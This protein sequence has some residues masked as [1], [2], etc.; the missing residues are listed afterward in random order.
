MTTLEQII[1]DYKEGKVSTQALKKQLKEIQEQEEAKTYPLSVG[2]RGLWLLHREGDATVSAYNVPLVLRFDTKISETRI[3]K[4]CKELVNIHRLLGASFSLETPTYKLPR[5]PYIDFQILDQTGKSASEIVTFMQQL[6]DDPLAIDKAPVRFRWIPQQG[7]GGYLQLV[8]HHLVCD[9]TSLVTIF[10]TLMKLLLSENIEPVMPYED[11]VNWEQSFLK[12]PKHKSLQSYWKQILQQLPDPVSLHKDYYLDKPAN[13]IGAIHQEDFP[14]TVSKKIQSYCRQHRISVASVLLGAYQ[15]VLRKYTGQDDLI[16]GIPTLGRSQE[17][18][19]QTVGYCVNMIPIRKPVKATDSISTYLKSLQ[20]KVMEGVD[21]SNYPFP[22]MVKDHNDETL[23]QQSLP[24]FQF[25]FAYQNFIRAGAASNLTKPFENELGVH[26]LRSVHQYSNYE[27]AIEVGEIEEGFDITVKYNRALLSGERIQRFT[28]HYFTVLKAILEGTITQIQEL[29]LF[30]DDER[31]LLDEVQNTAVTYPQKS[32]IAAYL[33][34]TEL[35][36]D[37]EAIRFDQGSLTHG[38]VSEKVD[39]IATYLLDQGVRSEGRIG[40]CMQR[41]PDLVLAIM[42]ILRAGATF[43]P[44]SPDFPK[45][46]I[47]YILEDANIQCVIGDVQTTSVLQQIVSDTISVISAIEMQKHTNKQQ[48]PAISDQQQA[49]II[50]TSGSTG[51]PKGVPVTHANI[52]NT[53]HYLEA[54]YPLNAKD[55]YVFKTNYV[56]DVS[57]SEIFGWLIGKGVLYIPDLGVEKSPAKLVKMIEE[58][59]ITHIN[60]V[61]SLLRVF[62]NYVKEKNRVKECGTLKYILVAGEAFPVDLVREAVSLFSQSQVV[63]IYGPTEASIY[64][65]AFDCSKESFHA[66]NTPIGRPIANT[67]LHIRDID[68]QETGM[69]VPG[70]LCLSGNGVVSG[71]LNREELSAEKFIVNT[72]SSDPILYRTGDWV[73][74]LPDGKIEY[75]GRIDAQVKIRGYRI[76]LGE[77]EYAIRKIPTIDDVVCLVKAVHGV[78]QIWSFVQAKNSQLISGLQQQL[79]NSLPDYMVPSQIIWVPNIPVTLNGKIDRQKLLEIRPSKQQRTNAAQQSPKQPEKLLETLQVI[80]KETLE[81]AEVEVD[82]RFMEIGGD[83]ILAAVLIDRVNLTF[84]TSFDSADIF[85][86]PTIQLLAA[87]IKASNLKDENTEVERTEELLQEDISSEKRKKDPYEDAIAIVGMSCSFPG[88]QNIQDFWNLLIAEKESFRFL[89]ADE[90]MKM[91][92]PDTIIQNPQFVPVQAALDT[93]EFFDAPFF[94]V[95]KRDAG[96]MDPQLRMLLQHAWHAV[97]DAGY[98]VEKIKDTAVYI[99]SGNNFY[100][101]SLPEFADQGSG[102]L[103]HSDQYVSWIYGQGGTIPTMISYKLGLEGPSLYVH[104]NCSSSLSGLY[105]AYQSIMNGE[106]RHA[107]VGAANVGAFNSAGYIH[108]QGLNFSGD[109][110]LKAFDKDAD[111]MIGGEGVTMILVKKASEAIRDKDPIYCILKGIALNNDGSDKAGFYAPSFEGQKKVIKKVLDQT[112]IHPDSISYVEAHGTGTKLGDPIEFNALADT[113]KQY[114]DKKEYCAI[115]SVKT[116][117]GHVDTAAGLAGVIKIALSMQHQQLPA[118]LNYSS[119]NPQLKLEGSPFFISDKTRSWKRNGTPLRAAISSFGIGGTNGHAVFEQVEVAQSKES[120]S[121]P[122]PNQMVLPI[123]ARTLKRLKQYVQNI[124]DFV[125]KPNDSI[126]ISDQINTTQK[127]ESNLQ[128]FL[129]ALLN[130]AADQIDPDQVFDD[131]IS[132]TFHIKKISQW[133][134]EFYSVSLESKE[135]FQLNTLAKLS[136][137]LE[138]QL[139]PASK[140]LQFSWKQ[141]ADLCYTFQNGRKEMKHR[142]VFVFDS[143]EMLEKQWKAFLQDKNY[144]G[145]LSTDKMLGRDHEKALSG[146]LSLEEIA[147]AW[148]AGNKVD[149]EDCWTTCYIPMRISAPGYPFEE[150]R[151]PLPNTKKDTISNGIKPQGWHPLLHQNQSGFA[152]VVFQ[153]NFSGLEFFLNDHVIDGNKILP[154]VAYL[155]MALQAYYRAQG[156]APKPC[157]L[158]DIYWMQPWIQETSEQEIQCKLKL[159]A[160]A[161]LYEYSV[162]TEKGTILHSKGSIRTLNSSEKEHNHIAIE[163]FQSTASTVLTKTQIYEVFEKHKVS[164]G[165]RHRVIE[166]LWIEGNHTLVRLMMPQITEETCYWLHPAMMDGAL[167]AVIGFKIA[168]EDKSVA[169]PFGIQ[170]VVVYQPCVTQ[171]WA[172]VEKHAAQKGTTYDIYMLNDEKEVCVVIKGYQTRRIQGLDDMSA[173]ELAQEKKEDTVQV[174]SPEWVSRDAVVTD[175]WKPNVC[176]VWGIDTSV[177]EQLKKSGTTVIS[178]ATCVNR[179]D[180]KEIIRFH[181]PTEIACLIGNE[182]EEQPEDSVTFLIDAVFE[183][184]KAL[185]EEGYAAKALRW[186]V[187]TEATFQVQPEETIHHPI[188]VS[189][190]GMLGS[191]QKEYANWDIRLIDL[192]VWEQPWVQLSLPKTPHGVSWARRN[193]QW[194]QQQLLPTTIQKPFVKDKKKTKAVHPVIVIVGGAGTVGRA[195]TNHLYENTMATVVW[196]GR[197]SVDQIDWKGWESR[198]RYVQADITSAIEFENALQN[199]QNQVGPIDTLVHTTMVLADGS[200]EKLTPEQFH[201]TFDNKALGLVVIAN[202]LR[203]IRVRQLVCFSSVAS[204]VRV[205]GQTNYSAGCVFTDQYAQWIQQQ[206]SI[207]VKIINW[208]YWGLTESTEEQGTHK[209]IIDRG[210]EVLQVAPALSFLDHFLQTGKQQLVYMKLSESL[211]NTPLG[212]ELMQGASRKPSV[213]E[214]ITTPAKVRIKN[215]AMNNSTTT[216]LEQE[217]TTYLQG[218]IADVLRMEAAEIDTEEALE[219][220]GLDSILV[221]QITNELSSVFEGLQTTV[222]FEYQTI[223]EIATYLCETYPEIAQD[224]FGKQDVLDE[225]EEVVSVESTEDNEALDVIS[226]L[227][228]NPLAIPSKLST[229][230][231]SWLKQ[232]VSETTELQLSEIDERDSLD[233]YSLDSVQIIGLTEHLNSVVDEIPTTVFFESEN[234]QELANYLIS[235]RKDQLDA[236]FGSSIAPSSPVMTATKPIEPQ[237]HKP[238]TQKTEQSK[239]LSETDVAII[240]VTGSYPMAKDLEEFWKNLKEGKDCIS[241]VPSDR[242]D[243]AA[244]YD[245]DK[246]NFEKSYGKWGGFLSDV[247][248]FDPLFFNISPTEAEIMDPKERIFLETVWKLFEKTGLTRQKIKEEYD[249]MVGVYVGAMY[250]HYHCYSADILKES[251]VSMSCHSSIA[252]RVSYYFNLQGPSVAVN[253]MC[254]SSLIA[255]DMAY[256]ALLTGD[257]E[258]A[259]AGG[260]NLSLHPK[261]YIGLSATRTM[262]SHIDSRSFSDGDGYLPAEGVGAVLLKPLSRAIED[263]DQIL[264]VIKASSSNHGGR[265][266]GFTVPNLKAQTRLIEQNFKRSGI[267]PRTISYVE[268]AVNGSNLG[269]PIEIAALSKAFRKFTGEKEFCSIGTVKSNIGHAE[270]ASGIS[271]LTKV[272]LQMEHKTLVPTIKTEPM[273]QQIQ[274]GETPFVLQRT[275]TPWERPVISKVDETGIEKLTEYPRRATVSSFGAGGSNAHIIIEEYVGNVGEKAQEEVKITEKL[276]NIFVLSARK[277]EELQL[278]VQQ[279]YNYIEKNPEISITDIA[280]TLQTG[281][282]LMEHRLAIPYQS[283]E[284]LLGVLRAITQ[285]TSWKEAIKNPNVFT[286]DKKSA[287]PQITQLFKDTIGTEIL[288]LVLNRGDLNK[289]AI[290]WMSGSLIPWESIYQNIRKPSIVSLPGYPFQKKR[291]W[292]AEKNVV[293]KAPQQNVTSSK[294]QSENTISEVEVLS[295]TKSGSIK[296]L[297]KDVWQEVLGIDSIEWEDNF[298][299]LGGDSIMLTHIISRIKKEM[300]FDVSVK[301]LYQSTTLNEMAEQLLEIAEQHQLDTKDMNFSVSE[302]TGQRIPRLPQVTEPTLSFAQQRLWFLDQMVKN[303]PAYNVVMALHMKGTLKKNYLEK[304]FHQILNRHESLRTTFKTKQGEPFQQ[305]TEQLHPKILWKDLTVITESDQNKVFEE[306]AKEEARHIFNLEDGTLVRLTVFQLNQQKQILVLNAHHIVIDGWSVNV[307]FK[308]L[309]E[310]YSQ[311]LLGKEL[312]L[313]ALPIQYTD[314]ALWQRKWLQGEELE[315]QMAYWR[316]KLGSVN[317]MIEL[318]LDH[319]RPPVQTFQGGSIRLELPSGLLEN[320]RATARTYQVTLF[321]LLMGS[322]NVLLHRYSGQQEIIVGTPVNNRNRLEIE[323]LIGFFVN[324]LVIKTSMQGNPSFPQ[325]LQRLREEVNGAKMHQDLPFEQLVQELQPDRNMSQNPLFQVCFNMLITPEIDSSDLEVL[326]I[327]GVRND[328]AKFDLWV[329]VID[330]KDKMVLEVE[331]NSV[332]FLE[333][334]IV[335]LMNSYET[336]LK[337]IIEDGDRTIGEIPILTKKQQQELVIKSQGDTPDFETAICLHQIIDRQCAQTPHAIAATFENKKITYQELHEM[338]NQLANYLIKEGVQAESFVGLCM[339]RSLD[340]IIC[341]LGILKAGAAYVPIDPSYPQDRLHYILED[342]NPPVVLSHGKHK[343]LFG[344]SLQKVCYLDEI[345]EVVQRCERFSVTGT[346]STEDQLAYMIYTSGSTGKPK[347]AMITHKSIVN[348]LLWMQNEYQIGNGDKILQKTPYSFDVSV[349][350]FFWPLMQGARLVFAK[351]EGH[352]DPGYLIELIEKK[353]ITVLHFV[354]SMLQVFLEIKKTAQCMSIQKV[355]CSGEALP[356]SL[357]Q[358]FFAG[359]E[360]AA[361]HNLYGPTEAAVDVTYWSCNREDTSGFIPIGYPVAHT[362]IY[363]LDSYGNQVPQGVTGEIH[364]GGV[365]VARGYHNKEDLTKDKFIT[366]PFSLSGEGT[367]YKTGDLGRMLSDGSIEYKGRI[368]FQVKIR[369]VRIELGEIEAA[370][371]RN[372][373][374][375]ETVV[376]AKSTSQDPQDKELVAYAV[377]DLELLEDWLPKTSD[378]QTIQQ[379]D[380]WEQVFD[381]TYE[382][383]SPEKDQKDFNIIGWNSSYTGEEI[384]ANEMKVWVE[385]TVTRILD[386]K[387]QKVLEIGCGT[388]LLVSR[389]APHV[390]HYTGTDISQTGLDYIQEE[391][392]PNLPRPEQLTL[393][394]QEANDFNRIDQ[395]RYDL[396]IINSVAQY[397]G[398]YNYFMEVLKGALLVLEDDGALFLGDIRNKGLL[399]SFVMDIERYKAAEETT[400]EVLQKQV[401]NKVFQEPELL[402]DPDFFRAIAVT[403][404]AISHV[405]LDLKR[406]AFQNE[407]TRYRYDVILHVLKEKKVPQQNTVLDFDKESQAWDQVQQFMKQG[408]WD[409]IVLRNIP[410]E[411]L[412][413]IRVWETMS[414][415]SP[416][417]IQIGQLKTQCNQIKSENEIDPETIYTVGQDMKYHV[418]V[419]PGSGKRPFV[420]DAIFVKKELID[421]GYLADE[422]Y[423][424]HEYRALDKYMNAPSLQ[425]LQ[426][427]VSD[428]IKKELQEKLPEYMIPGHIV[429]LDEM[430]VNFNGKLDRKALPDIQEMKLGQEVYIAPQSP[431]QETLIDLWQ[432]ILKIETIGVADNFFKLG[433]HSLNV[434]SML[435]KAQDA[436]GGQKVSLVD[437][438]KTPTIQGLEALLAVSEEAVSPKGI[439]QELVGAETT[440]LTVLFVPYAGGAATAFHPIA[441]AI[442]QKDATISSWAVALPGNEYGEEKEEVSIQE[443][444]SRCITEINEKVKGPIAIY[445]HCVGSYLALEIAQRLENRPRNLEFVMLG[446]LL[447]IPKWYRMLPAKDPWIHKSDDELIRMLRKWGMREEAVEQDILQFMVKNFRIDAKQSYL[448]SKTRKDWKLT[449]PIINVVGTKD[450][451]TKNYQKKYKKWKEYG[452]RVHLA[453]VDTTNH[454]FVSE[455]AEEVAEIMQLVRSNPEVIQEQDLKIL[456]TL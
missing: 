297:L 414:A 198:R 194:Y 449:A 205:P 153:S 265:S 356:Y 127:I 218:V 438:Y 370:L 264:G 425:A 1:L 455:L 9:G 100:R 180:F 319:P 56:F 162:I 290:F 426:K 288:N 225:Q 441:Q 52:L 2:Q 400:L 390:Q 95:S 60:F 62:I 401:K 391:L 197:R 67:Q 266:N 121:Q 58:Q 253:T 23:L 82:D 373:I 55:V 363:I 228:E 159:A 383:G 54:T 275:T 376:L 213:V 47:Q 154:G 68:G 450:P 384:P 263:K 454:Y 341:L 372:P 98:P 274:L 348:R 78:K 433:G 19:E 175:L 35:N 179:S 260:V 237:Q 124:Y 256:K 31:Q 224:H 66:V 148:V 255:I 65:A 406:G 219:S 74:R 245:P 303:S 448:Y 445:G 411:R 335:R 379:T 336:L 296:E 340:M 287:N 229:Q 243:V 89:Q 176:W 120:T 381:N 160:T 233:T 321:E 360:K 221:V 51:K 106:C 431:T 332:I 446:G 143:P 15:L 130:V 72:Y 305:V 280:Y 145:I 164:Y 70:E 306:Q 419:V 330:Q 359:F 257:C 34:N 357:V 323:G 75:I 378:S 393:Y 388:G 144:Q 351:P 215:T 314:Y 302:Q 453:T 71:Y 77:I 420:V 138:T 94:K 276:P 16:I 308:E 172:Y 169:L 444:A 365:Q 131:Y 385:T 69:G 327:Q 254:S 173:T 331:Y 6:N 81:I 201:K 141:L 99:S 3:W 63:N 41:S 291:Y 333:E 108:Q 399:Q 223:I 232:R 29:V 417:E 354:P 317:S 185:L 387:P 157:V 386:L 50:Y 241:E 80:W 113:Y 125:C 170:E 91:D 318:P 267:D 324:T 152:G 135:L 184:S 207:D 39:R 283:R 416:K 25:T 22:L 38:M 424:T 364:I 32:N 196:I 193:Q 248:Q 436:V 24:V 310:Q 320:L 104:S 439:I 369:G 285:E 36:I 203:K 114:T 40:V 410:N 252:N 46:R 366:D 262:G 358:R 112:E 451:I 110:R 8:L 142:I 202:T 326:D 90:L 235:N 240:G 238:S 242:W 177:V 415:Q 334:T 85:Q 204:F 311:L 395:Q 244:F 18:Y 440:R 44:I 189:C 404:P 211:L 295:M 398:N 286:A 115:G 11:F 349:W 53:L 456:D 134:S 289:I 430:P 49:Y 380:D 371:D 342:S 396:V 87:A 322:F 14:E 97:E 236:Y 329:N 402:I 73:R 147:M 166:T 182:T 165:P 168:T 337:E 117:L 155:E 109:G 118:S 367:L 339:E 307:F 27:L 313:P 17:A 188:G 136:A 418:T 277:E 270:A 21:H 122:F 269:D 200:F 249:A 346:S 28:K 292:I 42:G 282:E 272:L 129:G 57:L 447:P 217:I 43:V 421:Q 45:D 278:M 281:R 86:Y 429:L 20:H 187:L 123:S 5:S 79:K 397:F 156:I 151:F 30:A 394:K 250:Q 227:D 126:K 299:A 428:Q 355:F 284:Q 443:I 59:G 309:F 140:A 408:T 163:D 190:H 133:I 338:T 375:K 304:S 158:N 315:S 300:P 33:R 328:T 92:V 178:L 84:K 26:I 422:T 76:E 271:Q 293:N 350:E 119:P 251:V 161:E 192:D 279:Q 7:S 103:K 230:V 409:Q 344:D 208:G 102:V 183:L 434:V 345:Q 298:Q 423:L 128:K 146:V 61:P 427:V 88:V 435:V 137:Y 261:K 247:D 412:R 171:M 10:H 382:V 64:A 301:T 96:F 220:Y 48:F 206:Y 312:Q 209:K 12:N 174:L 377:P 214:T 186:N 149:W 234:I 343:K 167:Q 294:K 259:I 116:N 392:Q 403:L 132:D 325:F 101:A 268:S 432:N 362:Q 111:G 107:L 452:R 191:L 368:D 413:A 258:I 361:L 352:K 13:F 210:V 246:D 231:I 316:S 405:T 273:N 83:S 37:K 374:L 222:F 150:M 226:V 407:L 93:K 216:S 239:I 199:V 389:I 212:K 437:F 105:S 181:T 139:V 4:A 195:Y 442:H 347:G 353:S